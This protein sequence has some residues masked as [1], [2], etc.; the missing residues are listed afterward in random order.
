MCVAG[1]RKILCRRIAEI[2]HLSFLC[3][4]RRVYE[5]IP[6]QLEV[7]HHAVAPDLAKSPKAMAQT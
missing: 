5:L 7:P 1:V 3:R 2:G 6:S 4:V